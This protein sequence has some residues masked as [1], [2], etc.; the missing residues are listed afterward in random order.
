MLRGEAG[1]YYAD[2]YP[3]ISFYS[4]F[5]MAF[6]SS[7]LQWFTGSETLP[8]LDICDCECADMLP[9]FVLLEDRRDHYCRT[10]SMSN[11]SSFIITIEMLRYLR[12]TLLKASGKTSL[13]NVIGNGQVRH[14]DVCRRSLYAPTN[15]MCLPRLLVE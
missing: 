14:L 6:F 1:V 5:V 11:N 9:Q 15:T 10:S 8:C 7:L 4:E 2:L 3:L 13:V 12:M